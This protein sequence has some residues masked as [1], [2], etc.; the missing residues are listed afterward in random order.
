M[1][2][3]SLRVL[4]TTDAVGGVWT[5]ATNLAKELCGR[6]HAVTL[7]C[8]GPPPASHKLAAIQ[9]TL[10]L[11]LHITDLALEWMDPD[12]GDERRAER[13]LCEIEREAKPDIIHL[14]SFREGKFDWRAPR[15][16]TAHSC[17]RSWAL[18]CRGTELEGANWRIY[19]TN[20]RDGLS[21]VQMW[22][23]PT[24]WY[25]DRVEELH[26]PAVRGKVIRNGIG[27]LDMGGEKLPR[28]MAA[29]RFR[30]EAKNLKVLF[31]AA[32]DVAWPI[33]VAG[34]VPE[35]MTRSHRI[36]WLGALAHGELLARLGATEIFVSPAIYEPFG[37]SALEAAASGCALIL[38]DIGSFRELWEGAAVFVEPSDSRALARSINGLIDDQRRRRQLQREA[39]RRSETYSLAGM[40][41]AYRDVYRQLAGEQGS[42]A[43]RASAMGVA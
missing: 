38:S 8:L 39:R 30:D 41:D 40:A 29:G 27:K 23:A 1:R 28:V 11:A 43:R 42:G 37:L 5:F 17:V 10:G 24:R 31:D 36:E 7:V 15:L 21:S 12:G 6:G 19:D 35:A 3:G 14:N 25:H 22:A 16:L 18:A 13:R 26:A 32:E 9:D 4:M 20:V 2:L 34:P 33:A